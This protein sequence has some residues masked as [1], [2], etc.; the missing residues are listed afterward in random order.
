LKEPYQ[1]SSSLPTNQITKKYLT[2][3]FHS[4]AL[5]VLFIETSMMFKSKRHIVIEAIP[6]P[7]EMGEVAPMYFKVWK[8]FG[9]GCSIKG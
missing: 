1:H 9:P 6:V 2:K 7:R 4:L 5:D 8:G 3:M